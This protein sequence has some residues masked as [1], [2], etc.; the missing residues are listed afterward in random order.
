MLTT[1]LN[2]NEAINNYILE[3]NLPYYS[4]LKNPMINLVSGITITE[5]SKNLSLIYSKLTCNRD[6]STGSRLLSSHSWNHE[7]VTDERIF[8]AISEISN[9]WKDDDVGF[10]IIDDTLSKKDI[11]TKHIEGLDFHNSHADVTKPM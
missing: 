3:L 1:I 4:T 5:G 2:H 10:L 11:S 7:Y 6:S 9:T 8:H